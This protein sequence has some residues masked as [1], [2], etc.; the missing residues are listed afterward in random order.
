MTFL[1]ILMLPS[2]T[3]SADAQG[4]LVV[5]GGFDTDASGWTINGGSYF[6]VKNGNPPPDLVVA[7]TVSQ[8]VSS[9]TPG[10]VYDVSGD[11]YNIAGLGTIPTDNSF[12]VAIDGAFLFEA[13]AQTPYVWRSFDFSYTA[14]SSSALL[15]FSSEMNGTGISYMIDN[16]EMYAVPEPSAFSLFILGSGVLIY[17][18]TRKRPICSM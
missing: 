8:T 14:T 16:I 9:L 7:G 2:L 17:V 11:Y 1:T 5:N 12:G 3:Q 10:F 4:N 6:N 15:G 13:A 18:R